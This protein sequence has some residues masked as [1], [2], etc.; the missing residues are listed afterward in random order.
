MKFFAALTLVIATIV[1]ANPLDK[2]ATSQTNNFDDVQ[3]TRLNLVNASFG[4]SKGLY[5][6]GI[7]LTEIFDKGGPLQAVSAQSKPNVLAYGK[8]DK[9][10]DPYPYITSKYSGSTGTF[11]LQSFYYGCILGNLAGSCTIFLA[12]Y[13][14]SQRVAGTQF[15]YRPSG[16]FASNMTQ[17]ILDSTFKGLDSV[18]FVTV[19]TDRATNPGLGGATFLDNIQYTLNSA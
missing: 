19:F 2:R 9:L 12:G 15:D 10:S 4:P 7:G 13:K 8:L 3:G 18:R 16:R 1:S 11:D 14:N 6:K 5:Y 17:I